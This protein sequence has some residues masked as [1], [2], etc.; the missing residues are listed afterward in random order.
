MSKVYEA[1]L[2]LEE[3]CSLSSIEELMVQY[4]DAVDSIMSAQQEL[5]NEE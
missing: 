1:Y 2:E 3:E 5:D 4:C